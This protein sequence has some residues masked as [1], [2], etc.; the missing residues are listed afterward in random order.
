MEFK[1]IRDFVDSVGNRYSSKILYRYFYDGRIVERTYEEMRDDVYS[2]A[3]YFVSKGFKRKHIA[4]LGGTSYEWVVSFLAIIISDNVAIPL[5]KMLPEN[6]IVFLCNSGDV[7]LLLHDSD[8][9]N[10][11][12]AVC[13]ECASVDEAMCL[14]SDEFRKL[15]DFEVCELPA[16][17]ISDLCEILFTSGTTGTSKG[18]ML[19]QTALLA[20]ID[21]IHRLDYT[22]NFTKKT[23][24]VVMSVLPI[25]HTFELTVD[26]LG[27]MAYG[28]T[29]CINDSIENIVTNLNIFK[30]SVMLV[31][32][33]IA[34]AFYKKIKEG[35]KDSKTEKKLRK[36]KKLT[37]RLSNVGID[38]RRSVYKSVHEKLGG[39]LLNIVVGGA[40]LRPEICDYFEEFGIHLYQGYGLTE[41]APLVAADYPEMNRVG[42]VGRCVSYMDVRI[43]NEEIQVKG[44]GVM[45][46]YYHNEEATKEAFE[47]GWFKTGDLGRID[48]DGFLYITGRCKNLIILD[49]GKNVYPEELEEKINLLPGVKESFVYSDKGKICALVLPENFSDKDLVKNIKK[50]IKNLNE[51][52]PTYK[53]IVS[54]NMTAKEF[55]KTTTLKIKRHELMKNI[56]AQLAKDQVRYVAPSNPTEE[57]IV[58]AYE[59]VLFKKV[60]ML[61]DFFNL[62]GDSLTAFEAAAILGVNAQ[63]LY[64]HP[65]PEMMASYLNG[66]NFQSEKEEYVDVNA[67]IAKHANIRY[68]SAEEPY[69]LLTGATGYLGTHILE[70]LMK[71]GVKVVC[72]IRSEE[73]LRST[74][75]KYFPKDAAGYNYKVVKGDICDRHFGLSDEEYRILAS[76]ITTVIHTAANVHHTGYYEEFEKTNV[77]G[78]KN[79]IE[80]CKDAEAVLHHTSTASVNGVGTVPIAEGAKVFDEFILDI[81]QNYVQNVYIHSKYKA[82]EAVLK[83][84]AQGL[85][86]NIYRIGN[87]T[88]RKKDGVFQKNAQDNG[89]IARAKGLF[90]TRIFCE[91]IAEFPMDFTPVDE[92]AD[93]YVKLVFSN[94]IN[95]I[96]HLYNPN[97]LTIENLSSKL[98]LKCTMVPKTIYEKLLREKM[99]DKDVA[100]LSFYSAIATNSRNVPIK[101]DFTVSALEG[102]DFKWSK[103]G[104]G[105]LKYFKQ[106]I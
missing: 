29:I 70:R 42:S 91:E 74:L 69:I 97:M 9:K 67:L 3:S 85:K 27:I 17:D 73:R 38:A 89:F 92:C 59:Q 104:M 11:A 31:V 30:P 100:V 86:A 95:N 45:M 28:A 102:L 43:K 94:R 37:K 13:R 2:L 93:A 77:I 14:S 55:P 65:T 83:A 50:A 7:N 44:P 61:D 39:N 84:R 25:Y 82:E 87:L 48:E 98:Y 72:L 101:C 80:F 19:S 78:T 88:W 99:Q 21:E 58:A 56:E 33:A 12:E 106:F 62:G 40:A 41:C 76:K 23:K 60:G 105:Y 90:K 51:D 103:I 53:K 15:L 64:E 20:N 35:T 36:A 63:E 22:S 49:N 8:Y 34:E 5:D 32:P 47:D 71:R 46:G 18:V 81:G 1:S 57:R 6:E 75:A 24:A 66:Q 10:T 96:Y 16:T 68:K 54:V 79:V 52:L 26:N 4:I